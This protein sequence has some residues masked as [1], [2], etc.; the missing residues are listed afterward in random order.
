MRKIR[1]K[2][3]LILSVVVSFMMLAGSCT[4]DKNPSSNSGIEEL[5]HQDIQSE[6][7]NQPAISDPVFG[8]MVLEVQGND[9]EIQH[10]DAFYNCCIEYAVNY[11][12]ENFDITAYESD[13]ANTPCFCD[14]YF[15]LKS[16]LFHLPEGLYTVTLIDMEGNTVGSDTVTVGG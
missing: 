1:F 11:Q 15:N 9:L 6:C 13:A 5:A 14:C 2:D 3:Y 16:T 4:E 8:Y 7:L 10:L 12:I